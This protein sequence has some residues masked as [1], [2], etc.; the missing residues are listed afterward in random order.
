MAPRALRPLTVETMS[1][2]R[3]PRPAFP[4][5]VSD[6][7]FD[8]PFD[9]E[10]DDLPIVDVRADIEDDQAK[11]ATERAFGGRAEDSSASE[12]QAE[13]VA[14]SS[15]PAD[16]PSPEAPSSPI[17]EPSRPR[18]V[19]PSVIQPEIEL[20]R[21]LQNDQERSNHR[22]RTLT[23][24]D[25]KRADTRKAKAAKN[26][27]AMAQDQIPPLLAAIESARLDNHQIAARQ[28]LVLEP[29]VEPELVSLSGTVEIP[30]VQPSGPVVSRTRSR[31]RWIAVRN[32]DGFL[33]GQRWKRRLPKYCW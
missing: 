33:P 4:A 20:Q 17:E 28:E 21:Q 22:G 2:A 1:R 23:E 10:P 13:Q 29:S 30:H 24:G 3:N 9:C 16:A 31:P 32:K 18:R 11:R 5:G 14:G 6:T 19:L 26:Q 7:Q 12:G 25:A 27:L 15:S 8:F